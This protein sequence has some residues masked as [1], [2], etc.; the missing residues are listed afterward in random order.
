[1][2]PLNG[3]AEKPELSRADLVVIDVGGGDILHGFLRLVFN[4]KGVFL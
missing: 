4:E 2:F 3:M 1:M